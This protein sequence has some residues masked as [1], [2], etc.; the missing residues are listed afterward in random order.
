MKQ[1]KLFDDFYQFNSGSDFIPIT[2]NQYLLLGSEPLLVHTGS[3]DQTKELL[4]KIK[5]LLGSQ[6]LS[7]IFVSHFES[8]ECGGL[9]FLLEHYPQAKTICSEITARQLKGFGITHE[10]I[11]KKPNET[12]E[13]DDYQLNFIAYPSE[14][15]LWEGLLAMEEKRGI[16]FS[17]DLFIRMGNITDPIVDSKWE[18]EV[19]NIT[20]QSIPSSSAREALQSTLLNLPVR[21]VAL[22]HGPFL[23]VQ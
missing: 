18:E 3:I 17:A 2:F 16:F 6:Q 4:P 11:I 10:I 12:L 5:D 7:Y 14:M 8:D 15:H 9:G 23:K 13:I 20:D 22:G 19:K 1:V 21:Y